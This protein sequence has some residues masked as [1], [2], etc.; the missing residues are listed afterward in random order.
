[1]LIN[2]QKISLKASAVK[3]QFLAKLPP[4]LTR[5]FRIYATVWDIQHIFETDTASFVAS[6]Q[7]YLKE[8]AESN[9]VQAIRTVEHD[10]LLCNGLSQILRRFSFSSSCRTFWC[11]T[12]M[13]VQCSKQGSTTAGTMPPHVKK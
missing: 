7:H 5:V 10:T 8:F 4:H 2:F 12:K 3:V 9:V 13:Q 6:R 11:T 1:M